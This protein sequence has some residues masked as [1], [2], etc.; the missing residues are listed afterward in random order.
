MKIQTLSILLVITS[1]MTTGTALHAQG[2]C[3]GGGASHES[4]AAGAAATGDQS[5]HCGAQTAVATNDAAPRAVLSQ[6]AQSVFDK[7]IKAQTTLAQDSLQGISEAASAI[8][9]TIQGDSTKTFPPQVA[10][11]AGALAKA[12]NLE[13]AREAFKPLSESLI[14]YLKANKVPTGTYYEVYCEM[15]KAGWLQTDK[16]VRNPYFGRSMLRCGKIKS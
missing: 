13:S 2:C 8:T 9:E 12:K 10:E 11:Q 6:P 7:Y 3:G 15:A 5:S 1:G 14:Q 16:T 4:H